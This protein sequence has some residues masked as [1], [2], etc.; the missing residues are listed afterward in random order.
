MTEPFY[1]PVFAPEDLSLA[2]IERLNNGDVDGLLLLYED[3]AMMSINDGQT[4]AGHDEIREMLE[5]M[6][7]ELVVNDMLFFGERPSTLLQGK[8]ALT[9]RRYQV[10]YAQLGDQVVIRSGLTSEVA[11]RQADDTWLFG[12]VKTLF[13]DH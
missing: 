7:Y 2:F 1:P 12:M 11:R 8:L 9:T 6:V 13:V 10:R 4:A 3:A 5:K